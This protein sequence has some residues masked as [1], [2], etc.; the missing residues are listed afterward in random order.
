MVWMANASNPLPDTI[1]GV[2]VIADNDNLELTSENGTSYWFSDLVDSSSMDRVAM[3]LDSR[4]FVLGDRRSGTFLWESF[5]NPTHTFLPGM[6]MDD[7]LNLTSWVSAFHP[8]PG[9]FTFKPY[10]DKKDQ[11]SV[12]ANI[13][14]Q[15]LSNFSKNKVKNSQNFPSSYT[16]LVMNYSGEINI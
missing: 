16:R 15:L 14:T 4:N 3:L 8:A 7:G 5:K 2:L 9:N 10:D 13:V 6:I 11:H 12:Y 1:V